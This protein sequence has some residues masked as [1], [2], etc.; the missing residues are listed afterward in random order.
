MHI[1]NTTGKKGEDRAEQFLKHKKYIILERNYRKN[2]AEIDI[3]AIDTIKTPPVLVFVEVKTRT[4]TSFGTPLESITAR[5]LENIRKT[6][7]LY[8]VSHPNIPESYRIDA[9]SIFNEEIEHV[10]N[11]TF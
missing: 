5:K 8:V 4:S 7:E 11:L 10:E 9:I 1:S 2:Y 3:I 6:I